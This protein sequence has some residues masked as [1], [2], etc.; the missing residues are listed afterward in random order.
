MKK[1]LG[2]DV[3][4][5]RIGVAKS[6]ILGILATPLEVINRNV[7]DPVKRIKELL[8]Q[9]NTNGLVIGLPKSLDGTVK[10]Q[11]EK[12][13]EFIAE[14]N[15]KIDDLEIFMVDERYSTVEAEHYLRNYSKRNPRER[16]QVVD[17]VAATI[18]LQK[19]LDMGK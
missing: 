19:F 4:D 12:V 5:V 10:R 18:I 8:I 9:E 7:T 3:G 11:V 13:N 1:Y 14:L 6:D 17:M 16:R 2:L 15:S